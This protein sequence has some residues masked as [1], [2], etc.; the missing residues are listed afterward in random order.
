MPEAE[1][2]SSLW[3]ELTPHCDLSC[4]FCYNDWRTAPKS[5][6]PTRIDFDTLCHGITRL[7]ERVKFSYVALSGGEPLLYPKLVHLTEFLTDRDQRTILTTNGRLFTEERAAA[8]K[9][10]GLSGIQVPLLSADP[11]LHDDLA[12]RP[13]W[14]TTIR[15]LAISL[16]LGLATTATFV[17]TRRNLH[18]LGNVVKLAEAIGVRRVL[19]NDLHPVGAAWENIEEVGLSSPEVRKAYEEARQATEEVELLLIPDPIA[20]DRAL[21]VDRRWLRWS[22]SPDGDL[23][24]CNQSTRVIAPLHG[25][26]DFELDEIADDFSVGHIGKYRNNVNNCR[27]FERQMDHDRGF[28]GSRA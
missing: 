5:E 12:G 26:S 11:E 20:M 16:H 8:L 18:Q 14:E 4:A 21:E 28:V 17:A 1:G 7:L 22:L 25:L 9:A 6:Y 23:K 19:V 2:V 3:L 10:A 27:C 24:L 13:C 15:A